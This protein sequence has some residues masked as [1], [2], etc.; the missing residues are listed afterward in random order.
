MRSE[1][2]N[3][4]S[5]LLTDRISF[6]ALSFRD[7]LLYFVAKSYSSFITG[8][9][10]LSPKY[11]EW[12]SYIR[13][14]RIYYFAVKNIPAY[15]DFIKDKEIKKW[16]DIPFTDKDSYIK[17][18]PTEQRC[19]DG[20][21]PSTHIAIDESSGSTGTPFNWVRSLRERRESHAFI[22]Y[23]STFCFGKK[24]WLTIN[25]F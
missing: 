17:K 23:F 9:R 14:R 2:I 12:T 15:K 10:F 8:F 22:S 19:F 4:K 16:K 1:I 24:P 7:V 11:L 25:A 3:K 5:P 18:Y 21:I 6:L 13:A 20:K